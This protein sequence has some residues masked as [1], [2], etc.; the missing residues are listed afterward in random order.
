VLHLYFLSIEKVFFKE[1]I[2]KEE[3]LKCTHKGTIEKCNFYCNL[4]NLFGKIEPNPR[5]I[6]LGAAKSPLVERGRK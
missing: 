2:S 3:N 6:F 1:L 5:G 4:C